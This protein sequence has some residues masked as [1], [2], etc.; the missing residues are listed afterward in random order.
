MGFR[1]PWNRYYAATR[2]GFPQRKCIL[3][4]ICTEI[5][6]VKYKEVIQFITTV[7]EFLRFHTNPSIQH[8]TNYHEIRSHMKRFIHAFNKSGRHFG[9]L[10][11]DVI[12]GKTL[13]TIFEF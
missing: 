1:P 8:Y 5:T 10:I 4:D 12:R 9:F 3:K 13:A 7:K 6:F 2:G 11:Y